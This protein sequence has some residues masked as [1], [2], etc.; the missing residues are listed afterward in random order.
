MGRIG[1]SNKYDKTRGGIVKV[2]FQHKYDFIGFFTEEPQLWFKLI[3]FR[4]CPGYQK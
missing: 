2:Y 4:D 1:V 3:D